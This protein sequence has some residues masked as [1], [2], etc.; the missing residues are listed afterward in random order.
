MDKSP[1]RIVKL[2]RLDGRRDERKLV[3]FESWS[4][5]N[6]ALRKMAQTAPVVSTHDVEFHITWMD[7]G[8]YEGVLSLTY[9]P[10]SDYDLAARIRYHIEVVA[11]LRRPSH[12]SWVDYTIALG[13]VPAD[14][15]EKWAKFVQDHDMGSEEAAASAA[16]SVPADELLSWLP[17][18]V[19]KKA[20]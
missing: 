10:R 14:L 8:E 5:A 19:E 20:S 15:R 9:N 18:T 13:K 3:R 11:G 12:L 7:G 16:A 6:E 2:K 17:V 4:R 1:V